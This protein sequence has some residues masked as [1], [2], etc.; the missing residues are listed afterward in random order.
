[1]S[2]A[3]SQRTYNAP[4]VVRCTFNLESGA[5]VAAI[6]RKGASIREYV[7]PGCA[8]RETAEYLTKKICWNRKDACPSFH[9]NICRKLHCAILHRGETTWVL[10]QTASWLLI[11]CDDTPDA[12]WN[13]ITTWKFLRVNDCGTISQLDVVISS[14]KASIPPK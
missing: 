1:M 7:D 6:C 5:D 9:T 8:F 14:S 13:Q 10:Y 11:M 4:M 3:L 12:Q 2:V